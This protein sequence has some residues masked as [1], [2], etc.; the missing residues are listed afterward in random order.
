[1]ILDRTVPA[2]KPTSDS[3]TLPTTGTLSERGER[4]IKAMNQGTCTPD[5]AKAA[6]DVLTAQSKLIEQSEVTER[7]EVI[8]SWLRA[9]NNAGR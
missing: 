7:L 3:L 5:Q 6:L 2:L 4:V 8:E 1:M 9:H